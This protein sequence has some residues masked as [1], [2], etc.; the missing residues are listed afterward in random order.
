MQEDAELSASR[1]PD[2]EVVR[3]RRGGDR[4]RDLPVE[5]HLDDGLAAQRHA[6][7]E[8]AAGLAVDDEA[9]EVARRVGHVAQKP[10][11]GPVDLEAGLRILDADVHFTLRADGDVA[12]HVAERRFPVRKLQPLGDGLELGRGG[13]HEQRGAEESRQNHEDTKATNWLFKR[14]LRV[15]SWLRDERSGSQCVSHKRG[16]DSMTD[17]GMNERAWALAD[18]VRRA[19]RRAAHRRRRRWQ[20]ARA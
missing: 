1:V 17:L 7:K 10:A 16:N 3:D 14:D 5:G 15:P 2:L 18:R 13:V 12:V 19:R 6:V 8:L 20:A 11:V 9:M 4:H